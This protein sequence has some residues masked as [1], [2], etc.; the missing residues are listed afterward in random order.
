MRAELELEEH[1]AV[2][3]LP[4]TIDIARVF[5]RTKR[6]ELIFESGT[7]VTKIVDVLPSKPENRRNKK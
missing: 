6:I 1:L 4:P 2:V 5:I 7:V 3:S